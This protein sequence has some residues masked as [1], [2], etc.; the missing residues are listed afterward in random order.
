MTKQGKVEGF[1]SNVRNADKL[2]GLVD[3][4]RDAVVE[5]QVRLLS[6]RSAPPWLISEPGLVTTRHLRNGLQSH[7]EPCFPNLTVCE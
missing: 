5:Y 6:S 3:D 1:F 4:I 2:G 7:C